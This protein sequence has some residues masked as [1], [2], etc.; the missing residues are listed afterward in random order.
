MSL[1]IRSHLP[2]AADSIA[3]DEA[4]KSMQRVEIAL[5]AGATGVAVVLFSV[6]SVL[7][8]LS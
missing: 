5:L 4:E 6:L 8:H 3:D 2:L 7:I 1:D